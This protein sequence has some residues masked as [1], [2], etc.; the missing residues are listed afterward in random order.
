MI[1]KDGV[2][3]EAGN[4][5]CLSLF[6]SCKTYLFTTIFM[7]IPYGMVWYGAVLEQYF[8]E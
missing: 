6:L 5:S 4:G 7:T 8:E 2:H 3:R 1:F